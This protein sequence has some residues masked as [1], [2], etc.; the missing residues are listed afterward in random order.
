MNITKEG[1]CCILGSYTDASG[2]TICNAPTT[3]HMTCEPNENVND[4]GCYCENATTLSGQCCDYNFTL[5]EDRE[6]CVCENDYCD[7]QVDEC[8]MCHN[9]CDEGNEECH[10]D[11]DMNVCEDDNN[12]CETCLSD[13][14][15]NESDC[16]SNCT[17]ADCDNDC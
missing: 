6:S 3:V 12:H 15:D 13:C 9:S 16:L 8:D 11:C 4:N 10:N 17:D 5:S 1:A 7:D 2:N 14:M